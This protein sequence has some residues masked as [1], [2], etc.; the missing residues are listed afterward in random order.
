MYIRN[1]I[2]PSKA[3]TI[4]PLTVSITQFSI[5]IGS[6]RAYLSR[7]SVR[8]HVGVQLLVFSATPY[9]NKNKNSSIDKVQNLEKE[10]EVNMQRLSPRFRSQQLFLSEICGEMFY[11]NLLKFVWRRHAGAH[12]H[13]HQ[14]GGRKATKTSVTEFCYKSVNLS[15]EE[16]RNIKIT[17]FSGA[18]TVQIGKF[19]EISHFFLTKITALLAVM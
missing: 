15:L 4:L 6:P 1:E 7:H 14:H 8:D 3:S 10:R 17:L 9:Q 16:L 11:P 18:W 12:L 2:G 13:G 5:V 19:P